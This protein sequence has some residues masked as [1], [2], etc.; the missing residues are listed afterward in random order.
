MKRNQLLD[1]ISIVR[2]VARMTHEIIERN[3]GVEDICLM[4]VKSRGV[5]LAE[6]INANIEKF[7]GVKVPIGYLD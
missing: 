6:R 2:A 5:P 3:R 7:E 1:E 4:G